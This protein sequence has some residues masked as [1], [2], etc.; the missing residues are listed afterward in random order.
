MKAVILSGGQGTRLHP[1]TQGRFPK[2]MAPLAGRPILEYLLRRLREDGVEE[3]C[4]T[5][6]CMG[7]QIRDFFG[8]GSALGL[9][10]T[11]REER[12][13]L[14]TAG[15]VRGCMDFIGNEDFL[16]LSGDG[17]FDFSLRPLMEAMQREPDGAAI[18]L[19]PQRVPTRFGT[20]LTDAS[21]RIRSF[22]EKPAW[23]QVV[24]D[25]VNTGIYGLSPAV[26]ERVPEGVPY[27]FGR[28]LFPALLR[29]G[30]PLTGVTMAGYWRDLGDPASYFR[31]NLDA[32][33]GR[34]RLPG[35]TCPVQE[36]PQEETSSFRWE[37]RLPT[38]NA[39]RLMRQLSETLM[40]AGADFTDGL[41]FRGAHIAPD[42]HGECVCIRSDDRAE[43]ERCLELVSRIMERGSEAAFSPSPCTK[44]RSSG[45]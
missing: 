28:E 20:A 24:T 45:D 27:D 22:V 31:A 3:V 15:A 25:L 44:K 19:S 1:V 14:G 2:P 13:P 33:E 41:T 11:Y 29:E 5:L 17:V 30:V 43:G 26:M 36:P 40:E 34:L 39:A 37:R 18:V 21:G 23:P 4:L 6:Q 10:L 42:G 8:D 32:L 16:V 7:G 35:L 12:E 38:R 9:A